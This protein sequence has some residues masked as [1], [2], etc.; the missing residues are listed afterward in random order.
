MSQHAAPLPATAARLPRSPGSLTWESL[1]RSLFSRLLAAFLIVSVPAITILTVVLSREESAVLTADATN[2]SINVSRA[3]TSKLEAWFK[4][5]EADVGNFAQLLGD[6]TSDPRLAQKISGLIRPDPG[7]TYDVVEVTDPAGKVLAASSTQL[8]VDL[9][10]QQ[11]LG[12]ATHGY[13]LAPPR[14]DQGRVLWLAAAPI[15]GSDG[16]LQG[17][18]VA[19]LK[20]SKLSDLVV[21]LEQEHRVSTV[22]QLV[23]ADHQLLYSS[24]WGKVTDSAAMVAAGSLQA[25]ADSEAVT[26]GLAGKSGGIRYT[27]A[28]G[29]DQISGYDIVLPVG[30]AMVVQQSAAAALQPV[31]DQN[32]IA[33]IVAIGAVLAALLVGFVFARFIVRP[34]AALS[35][36]AELVGRG[37]LGTRV[38]PTGAAEVRRM[39]NAF[40][41]MS[42]QLDAGAERMRSV[43]RQMAT[44]SADLTDVSQRLVASTSDQSAASTETAASMEELARAAASISETIEQVAGEAEQTREYLR[45][46]REDIQ[47]SSQRTSALVGRVSEINSLLELINEIADQTNLLSLNAAI[48]AARAGEA[49]RGFS[50]VAEEVRRLAERSKTSATDIGQIIG[51]AQTEAAATVMSMEKSS[52]QMHH[53]LEL[54][55]RVTEAS[56]QVRQIVQQQRAAT[57][58]AV[59]AIEQ[60]SIGSQELSETARQLSDAASTQAGSA[61]ELQRSAEAPP[62]A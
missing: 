45:E 3:A 6:N 39:G 17:L 26:L 41:A 32:R 58:Q 42:A 38:T 56:E 36:A 46:T 23:N 37:Q 43:S 53:S 31:A 51:S 59:Q 52:K 13:V 21:E 60:V 44:S 40:N 20:L 1:H 14:V 62:E 12:A 48:E 33:L 19:N 50:V 24:T 34:I 18:A 47:E 57:D 35:S 29:Q 9:S 7:D 27:D 2:A 16:L 22:L 28:S 15:H 54:M 55:E 10:G 5:R 4:A 25:R 61:E 11:W 8:Q 30:W 49:G